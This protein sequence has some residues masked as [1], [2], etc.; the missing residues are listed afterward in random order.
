MV[1]ALLLGGVE[2]LNGEDL[3]VLLDEWA[4]RK[5]D[6]HLLVLVRLWLLDNLLLFGNVVVFSPKEILKHV[7]VHV[8]CL[9]NSKRQARQSYRPV[10]DRGGKSDVAFLRLVEKLGLKLVNFVIKLL[11]YT[12]FFFFGK[13]LDAL[14]FLCKDFF[15]L[16]EPF[17]VDELCDEGV[18]VFNDLLQAEVDVTCFHP[19]V[20]D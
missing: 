6:K 14:P 4:H 11:F 13:R 10:I 1:V 15:L 2:R 9:A 20:N 8:E 5:L 16:L 19:L 17:A 3:A 7:G 18:D 12:Q